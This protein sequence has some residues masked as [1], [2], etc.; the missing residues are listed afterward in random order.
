MEENT[1]EGAGGGGS[2]ASSADSG[3][4]QGPRVT[5]TISP[6][7]KIVSRISMSFKSEKNTLSNSNFRTSSGS[8]AAGEG[9]STSTSQSGSNA[10]EIF[11]V[12]DIVGGLQADA[13]KSGGT[14]AV[15]GATGA[16]AV[17]SAFSALEQLK[18]VS[19][20]PGISDI[21]MN[22]VEEQGASGQL[23]VTG[24]SSKATAEEHQVDG[25]GSGAVS[26]PDECSDLSAGA[27]AAT[28]ETTTTLSPLESFQQAFTEILTAEGARIAAATKNVNNGGGA[29]N[30]NEPV[31]VPWYDE[32][33][34]WYIFNAVLQRPETVT[35]EQIIL[36]WVKSEVD[37]LTQFWKPGKTAGWATLVEIETL[38]AA[39]QT[40]GDMFDE[41]FAHVVKA[42]P[43]KRR[44][45]DDLPIA[46]TSTDHKNDLFGRVSLTNRE[47]GGVGYITAQL[48]TASLSR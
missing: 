22:V 36:G 6:K 43:R 42:L 20:P 47:L 17:A 48:V 38:K 44:R 32:L 30:N 24:N 9:S 27:S 33:H 41:R 7:N 46:M 29:S 13:A 25:S 21:T 34:N 14:S 11:S 1:N 45:I 5:M 37:G 12:E 18:Q 3:S 16:S 10:A 31:H 15:S 28:V 26:S 40:V 8:S 23:G 4:S 2:N 39:V 35:P 19:A